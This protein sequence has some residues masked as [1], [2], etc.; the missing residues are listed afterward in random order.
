MRDGPG[1]QLHAKRVPH[2]RGVLPACT[3]KRCQRIFDAKTCLM[4][5]ASNAVFFT[6]S[7]VRASASAPRNLGQRPKSGRVP[8]Q[9]ARVPGL[10]I[11]AFCRSLGVVTI[12]LWC[13]A[14]VHVSLEPLEE[15]S[16]CTK[17][18]IARAENRTPYT[19]GMVASFAE[20]VTLKQSLKANQPRRHDRRQ[21][22]KP[23]L[24]SRAC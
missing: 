7:G 14:G 19:P 1:K 4:G 8:I 20:R 5:H 21:A 12:R 10:P 23:L 22:G 13:E 16:R 24:A 6:T 9:G 11:Q 3:V 2:H 15:H 18:R 17:E